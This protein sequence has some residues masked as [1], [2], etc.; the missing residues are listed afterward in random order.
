MTKVKKLV[1]TACKR[2]TLVTKEPNKKQKAT[3]DVDAE[4]ET[5]LTLTVVSL[6][7]NTSTL[8]KLSSR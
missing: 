3:C 1:V 2:P 6:Q 7:T 8:L 4:E 5:F